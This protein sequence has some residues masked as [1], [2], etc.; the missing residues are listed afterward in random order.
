MRLQQVLIFL[1]L[2]TA[3]CSSSNADSVGT[4]ED[5]SDVGVASLVGTALILP[6]TRDDSDGVKQAA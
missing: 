4:W 2:L 1:L 3:I 6:Y 5:I